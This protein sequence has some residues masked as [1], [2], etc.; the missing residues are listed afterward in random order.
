MP[1]DICD[2]GLSLQFSLVCDMKW[3]VEIFPI[4]Q[5]G[6]SRVDTCKCQTH[7]S[8]RSWR[9]HGC[10]P[11]HRCRA[12]GAR[13]GRSWTSVYL[14]CD[15][16][17]WGT[18]L[19]NVTLREGNCGERHL[20]ILSVRVALIWLW[21]NRCVCIYR[22]FSSETNK[23][24]FKGTPWVHENVKMKIIH[25]SSEISVNLERL[26]SCTVLWYK[27]CRKC[28]KGRVNVSV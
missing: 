3:G 1:G 5:R 28:S 7:A 4:N 18:K 27:S 15:R 11:G 22:I 19:I 21:L 16:P 26:C 23:L 20:R 2:S 12:R 13:V 8:Q 6:H 24:N 17:L 14:L 10:G 25:G 9:W